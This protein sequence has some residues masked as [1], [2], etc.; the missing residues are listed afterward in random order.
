[1]KCVASAAFAILASLAL[2]GCAPVERGRA[3]DASSPASFAPV[4][5][6]RLSL[7]T[8][9]LASDEFEGRAPGT[10]GEEK[11]IAYLVQQFQSLG[12]EPGGENGG[13]TQKVPLIRTQLEKRGRISYTMSG[14]SRPLGLGEDIYLSTI[15]PV[16]RARI[17]NAPMVFVGYG[18]SAPERQWD[19]FKG[20]DLKGKV[21][22]FLV[23]DPDFEASAG[24]AVA[25][26]FGGRAMTYYGR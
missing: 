15:R 14:R 22:I 3:V 19:D 8:R 7:V 20:V 26:R 2:T 9:T 18:V 4:D 10:A 24:D 12:L 21:A 23:N 5:P 25:N 6:N 17:E 16:E 1:M 11:T 13:W